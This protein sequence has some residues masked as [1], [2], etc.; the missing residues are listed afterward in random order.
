MLLEETCKVFKKALLDYRAAAARAGGSAALQR[1]G[2][3]EREAALGRELAAIGR[4][5]PALHEPDGHYRV[6]FEA[7]QPA[8]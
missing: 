4:L 1:M 7:G 8:A 3:A 6:S 5:H 2:P